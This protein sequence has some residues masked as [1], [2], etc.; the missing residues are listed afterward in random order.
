MTHEEFAAI[1]CR[2][3]LFTHGPVPYDEHPRLQAQVMYEDYPVL[4]KYAEEQ[5]KGS[6]RE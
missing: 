6:A 4:L 5:M 1:A 3:K 2:A